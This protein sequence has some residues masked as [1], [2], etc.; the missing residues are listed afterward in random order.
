MRREEDRVYIKDENTRR[1]CNAKRCRETRARHA[2]MWSSHCALHSTPLDDAHTKRKHSRT[3]LRRIVSLS[4]TAA[5]QSSRPRGLP[6][7]GIFFRAIL[8]TVLGR[9]WLARRRAVVPTTRGR[10]IEAGFWGRF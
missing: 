1:E 4:R 9:V 8:R 10:G 5:L 7:V 2:R 3:C 6:P